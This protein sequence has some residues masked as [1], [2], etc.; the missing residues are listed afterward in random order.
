MAMALAELITKKYAKDTL[1]ILVFGDDAWQ[2]EIG[3]KN[4]QTILEHR[5]RA[6]ERRARALSEIAVRPDRRP[7]AVTP[8]G[9][10]LAEPVFT[11]SAGYLVA[12]GDSWFNYPLHDVLHEAVE[13]E[14]GTKK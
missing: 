11:Q 4:A 13:L 2:I 1:D 6:R 9:V 7:E 12:E 3:R 10:P 14:L 5:S 8:E